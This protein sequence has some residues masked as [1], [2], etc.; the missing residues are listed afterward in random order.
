PLLAEAGLG[1]S[2]NARATRVGRERGAGCM[3][4]W[5]SNTAGTLRQLL[6]RAMAR[7]LPR[8]AFLVSG[9]EECRRVCLTFDDG[10]HPVHT[11]RLLDALAEHR[12]RATFFIVGERA[13]RYGT[14]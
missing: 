11:P 14:I 1:R 12:V 2:R 3:I 4:G 6:K 8:R 9:P 10:P 5:P 7:A 13:A